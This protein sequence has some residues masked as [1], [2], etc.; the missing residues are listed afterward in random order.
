MALSLYQFVHIT[1]YILR[2]V[3]NDNGG[4]GGGSMIKTKMNERTNLKKTKYKKAEK[5]W[6]ERGMRE[7]LNLFGYGAAA[8]SLKG[9]SNNIQVVIRRIFSFFSRLFSS[10]AR[11]K[12]AQCCRKRL[13][14]YRSRNDA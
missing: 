6:S 2:R 8:V 5:K 13:E 10:Q 11:H 4:S 3:F 12:V 14:I 9:L 7:I 1:K